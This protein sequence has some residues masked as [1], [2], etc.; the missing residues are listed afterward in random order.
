MNVFRYGSLCCWSTVQLPEHAVGSHALFESARGLMGANG[1][2]QWKSETNLMERG[3]GPYG[4]TMIVTQVGWEVWGSADARAT[5]LRHGT[6]YWRF[7][8]TEVSG[9]PLGAAPNYPP[10]SLEHGEG[11]LEYPSLQVPDL[12]LTRG[13]YHMP[14]AMHI[15]GGTTFGILLDV[16]Q[17]APPVAM[18]TAVRFCL[19]GEFNSVIEIQ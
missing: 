7:M 8:Q 2:I 11:S 13:I 3:R 18:G 1:A 6:W 5:L 10:V 9:T 14:Q 12:P 4:M 16:A 19:Y 15:P 17:G